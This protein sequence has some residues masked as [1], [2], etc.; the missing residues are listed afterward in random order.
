[1][2]EITIDAVRRCLSAHVP[3]YSWRKPVYQH[4][5]LR[6]LQLLWNPAHRSALDV[7]G[8]TG[9]MAHTVKTLFALERVATVDVVDRFLASLD[10]ETSVYDGAT[11]PFADGSFDCVLLFNV[12]HHVPVGGRVELLR[13]CRRVA[14][15]GP[16]YIKDHLSTGAADKLRLTVLDLIGN[17]PFGGMVRADYLSADEWRE[18][19]ARSGHAPGEPLSGA[20]RRGPAAMW[21]PNRLE[22]SMRWL[23]L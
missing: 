10:V 12:L 20:Y 7:G 22:V 8:G 21:F 1:M 18:L 19:A 11:L 13:E 2:E 15:R 14:G 17:T 5:V 4:V 6:N 23:P 3:L 16:I 9:V